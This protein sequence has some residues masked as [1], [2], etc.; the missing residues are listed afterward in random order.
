MPNRKFAY[1]LFIYGLFMGVLAAANTFVPSLFTHDGLPAAFTST[2]LSIAVLCEMPLVFFSS[3][4]MDRL[5]SKVLLMAAM[6]LTLA[7]MLTYG[8]N[9]PMPM[10]IVVTMLTKNVASMLMI[11]VKWSI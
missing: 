1:Y 10:M 9:L 2:I 5:T 7:Q 3:K 6:M 4:F 8:L 11:M